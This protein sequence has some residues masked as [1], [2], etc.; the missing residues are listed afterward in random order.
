MAHFYASVNGS[1]GTTVTKCGTKNTGMQAEIRGWNVGVEVRL[2]HVN[3][4]DFV[5]VYKTSGSNGNTIGSLIAEYTEEV[6]L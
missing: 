4:K 5:Q 6:Q 3:G 1:R 2:S